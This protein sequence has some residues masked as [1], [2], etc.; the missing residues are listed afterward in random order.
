[1]I[2]TNITIF[3]TRGITKALILS[4]AVLFFSASCGEEAVE[5]D[6]D[7]ATQGGLPGSSVG[8]SLAT[9]DLSI[10]GSMQALSLVASP[11]EVIGVN[12]SVEGVLELSSAKMI[13]DGIRF[14]TETPDGTVDQADDSDESNSWAGPYL[15]D[16]LTNTVTPD[17]SNISIPDGVYKHLE[18]N[19]HKVSPEEAS[20]LGL[21]PSNPLYE[22]SIYIEGTYTPT[23]G[24]AVSFSMGY[25]LSERF[26]IA[27]P[28]G[29]S[30]SSGANSVI[31]A[32]RMMSWF[33]MS[34][35]ETN[36]DSYAF[37]DLALGDIVLDKDSVGNESQLRDVIKK[38][39]EFSADF[40]KD[41]DGDGEL[42]ESED[43]EVEE[44]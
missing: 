16:L 2:N 30:L 12:G 35:L 22:N 41:Q 11:V 32:F 44:I 4:S 21:D 29:M 3:F 8:A 14:K 34:D 36:P 1:M 23:G 27:G 19:V 38:N 42:S 25:D 31:I 20:S 6:S 33:D 43:A 13:L 39:I 24:S 26:I 5:G 9:V 28:A 7:P 10:S 17:I 37:S 18:L 15:V 40:G